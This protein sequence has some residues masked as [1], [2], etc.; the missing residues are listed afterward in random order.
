ML[1]RALTQCLTIIGEAAARVSGEGRDAAPGVPWRDV[2]GMRNW[3]VHAYFN[4]DLDT[5]WDTVVDDLPP[6][7]AA[8]ER[9]LT[10][11]PGETD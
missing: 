2:V 6:L 9:I 1:L 11:G 4:I 5:V 3:L 7:I 10:P 8:L